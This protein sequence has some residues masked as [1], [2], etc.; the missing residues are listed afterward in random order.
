LFLLLLKNWKQKLLVGFIES[1]TKLLW[2]LKS[3]AAKSDIAHAK[4][5]TR[6]DDDSMRRFFSLAPGEPKSFTLPVVAGACAARPA[7]LR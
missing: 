3:G 2:N 7:P 6:R 5:D 4:P 1:Q